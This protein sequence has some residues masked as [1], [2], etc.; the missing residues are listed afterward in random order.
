MHQHPA[1][2]NGFEDLS[3]RN[4]GPGGICVEVCPLLYSFPHLLIICRKQELTSLVMCFP[5][6]RS[7][8]PLPGYH[9][10]Y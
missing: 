5:N 7:A 3:L 4:P 2:P 9:R 6:L 10:G 1:A 8:S